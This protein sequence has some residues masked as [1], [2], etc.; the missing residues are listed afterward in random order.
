MDEEWRVLRQT[1][2]YEKARIRPALEA[3]WNTG[4]RP[5]IA[6]VD[7]RRDRSFAQIEPH[8]DAFLAAGP[9]VLTINSRSD[10][11]L[12]YERTPNLKAILVGGNRLSRGLTLEGLVV[13]YFVRESPYFDTLLQMGR[14]FGFRRDYVDLTRLWTTGTLEAW[15]RDLARTE[16][17]LRREIRLYS[18]LGR[19]PLDF[20]PRIRAHADMMIT[21]RN[22]MGAARIIQPDYFGRLVQT[23]KFRL[24]DRGWLEANLHATREFLEALGAPAEGGPS[25]PIWNR[26]DWRAVH[27]YL[28]RYQM[29]EDGRLD[30]DRLRDFVRMCGELEGGIRTWT[31]AVRGMPEV[32]G[33][34]G[35]IDLVPSAG[36]L[37]PAISRSRLRDEPNSIGSLVSPAVRGSGRGDELI[38]MSGE[39]VARAEAFVTDHGAVSF[40]DALRAHRDRDTGL[41]LIYPI[42]RHSKAGRGSKNRVDLFEDPVRHGETVIGL[43]MVFPRL[44]EGAPVYAGSVAPISGF[45]R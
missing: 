26:V 40:S 41:L 37:T 29:S 42:S 19:S 11:E 9:R 22:K 34:L 17:E 2:R 33:D 8:I 36:G 43:A 5:T 14:W 3:R 31:V 45:A 10:D 4:F 44:G 32:S 39:Q 16:E 12:D 20:G 25:Q 21:A 15:F 28:E 38:G 7:T 35:A 27:A 13:S 30:G 6:S 23:V 24:E 18:A 1:W